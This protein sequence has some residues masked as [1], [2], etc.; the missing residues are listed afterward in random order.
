MIWEHLVVEH[1]RVAPGA[2]RVRVTREASAL[3]PRAAVADLAWLVRSLE[4]LSHLDFISGLL[5]GVDSAPGSLLE[6]LVTA[7]VRAPRG[8]SQYERILTAHATRLHGA[9]AV[10]EVL[11]GYVARG[12]GDEARRS[13]EIL[14][15]WTEP[16]PAMK[17]R[18]QAAYARR[19]LV[20]TEVSVELCLV[21]LL[22]FDEGA[23][24]G[25]EREVMRRAR[26]KAQGHPD[27]GI[28]AAAERQ[29]EL[30]AVL[31]RMPA[32]MRPAWDVTVRG[33]RQALEDWPGP[34]DDTLSWVT[35][36]LGYPEEELHYFAVQAL[37]GAPPELLRATPVRRALVEAAV[38]EMDP[39]FDRVFVAPAVALFGADAI[40]SDLLDRM[41]AGDEAQAVGASR[42][43]YWVGRAVSADTALRRAQV[44]LRCFVAGS[45][46]LRV[47]LAG[48]FPLDEEACP[49]GMGHLLDL[50]REWA[51]DQDEES[52]RR[53]GNG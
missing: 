51:R 5:H 12:T 21:R 47:R 40:A 46:W 13:T 20:E 1:E 23:F 22:R 11:L 39:S 32:W 37:P 27:E 33:T 35:V 52:V 16:T 7:A 29:L 4:Q 50:V 41:E 17:T 3:W 45:P 43:L 42:A 6:P 18:R 53:W 10:E 31:A 36:A 34:A 25:A 26:E 14:T 19:L 48:R 15:W 44:H 49:P 8:G 28:R 2:E 9:S 24:A 38:R 30:A